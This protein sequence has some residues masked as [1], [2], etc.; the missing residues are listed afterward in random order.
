MSEKD[1]VL[2]RL[3]V[4]RNSVSIGYENIFSLTWIRTL[5]TVSVRSIQVCI[6]LWSMDIGSPKA[7]IDQS[8]YCS[9]TM[10]TW[11]KKWSGCI[12]DWEKKEYIAEDLRFLRDH[13]S[14]T[15]IIS[16][17]ADGWVGISAAF[18]EVYPFAVL[19]RCL[20]HIQRQ[21]KNY[22]SMNPKSQAG[23]DMKRLMVYDTFSNPLIFPWLWTDWKA[24]H[25]SY[26]NEK[27]IKPSG[28]WR[29]THIKLK[30]AI[31]HI[32]NALWDMFQSH[33]LSDPDIARSSNQLEWYFWV[34]TEEWIQEHKW[35]SPKRLESFI[36]LWIT[37]R[38]KK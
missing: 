34:F 8:R 29:Y 10:P 25:Q 20:V 19:Q 26:I 24:K 6:I 17:T 38:N 11:F 16:C 33:H 30:K 18:K 36:A 14:Y 31:A 21:V 5:L 15:D 37:F 3:Q 2:V 1:I 22:I 27:T 12:R 23:R 9:S 4:K 35:L 7:N 28:W 13:M 32:D